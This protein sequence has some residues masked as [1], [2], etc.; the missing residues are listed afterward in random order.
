MASENEATKEELDKDI[1]MLKINI[2]NGSFHDRYTVVFAFILSSVIAIFVIAATAFTQGI[3]SFDVSIV[4]SIS[5]FGSLIF[6]GYLNLKDYREDLNILQIMIDHVANG[7]RLPSIKK[8]IEWR[9]IKQRKNEQEVT[10]LSEKK[11]A[12]EIAFLFYGLLVGGLIGVFGNLWVYVL[13]KYL[14]NPQILSEPNY[15]VYLFVTSTIFFGLLT[16]SFVMFWVYA[17]KTEK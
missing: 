11:I 5:A 8:L 4:W 17:R 9:Q 12:R 3:W 6:L 1:E 2:V 15:Q 16:I 7:K 10:D 14:E 13:T